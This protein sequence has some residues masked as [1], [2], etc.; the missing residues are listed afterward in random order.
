MVLCRGGLE[1]AQPCRG[2]STYRRNARTSTLQILPLRRTPS[3][4]PS[5]R[6]FFLPPFRV[7]RWP[8]VRRAGAHAQLRAGSTS[9]TPGAPTNLRGGGR[10]ESDL[11][12]IEGGRLLVGESETCNL[13]VRTWKVKMRR[14]KRANPFLFCDAT[15]VM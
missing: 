2:T 10:G 4:S 5:P 7:R 3:P 8:C 13:S 15:S 12:R 11:R 14:E 6:A 1:G 9:P